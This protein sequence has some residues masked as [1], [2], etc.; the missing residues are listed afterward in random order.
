MHFSSIE[1]ILADEN[2][3]CW[4]YRTD[5][6]KAAR[7]E[8]WMDA[9][10]GQQPLVRQAVEWMDEFRFEEKSPS[11]QETEAAYRRL[12]ESITQTPVVSMSRRRTRWFIP[13]AAVLLLAGAAIWLTRDPRTKV[14]AQY[15][16]VLSHSLPDGSHV[17]L[18]AHSSIR[19][20]SDWKAGKDREVWLDGE[21]FFKVQKTSLKDRFIVH[22]NT[23][24]I[25]VTGTQFNAISRDDEASVLLTEGSVT[26]RSCNGEEIKLKPGDYVRI[27]NNSP[28]LQQTN[29]ERVLAWKQ[30]KLDFEN[31]PINEVAKIISR[32]YGIKVS[33]P[34]SAT[35]TRRISGVMPNDNLDVLLSALEATGSFRIRR[36]GDEVVISAP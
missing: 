8:A 17:M 32:H 30:S 12:Q 7:W 25:I 20:G 36:T 5:V 28:A 21:A 6:Q 15:G 18:N 34:D 10:P 3:L 1:E 14:E 35:G 33:L 31:T 29:A 19:I 4:Y 9:N 11:P 26:V 2:F 22:T 24:D 27:N 13:A 16:A 23:M